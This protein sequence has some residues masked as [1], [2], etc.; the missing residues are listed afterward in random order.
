M[1]VE[2]TIR[3][4]NPH[5][6]ARIGP[7]SQERNQRTCIARTSQRPECVENGGRPGT[8]D[9]LPRSRAIYGRLV[10]TSGPY[11]RTN[12]RT[13]PPMR[14]QELYHPCGRTST[15]GVVRALVAWCY[16]TAASPRSG[17][18]CV[19]EEKKH[20]TRNSGRS[21]RG[22]EHQL[23]VLKTRAGTCRGG[24]RREALSASSRQKSAL[25][26]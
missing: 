7:L 25:L 17:L 8:L 14:T 12:T 16:E 23:R 22:C 20:D 19:T 2:P 26:G 13:C 11:S 3:A 6:V 24:H 9:A 10:E 1:N 18:R 5:G 15:R 21:A 4:F